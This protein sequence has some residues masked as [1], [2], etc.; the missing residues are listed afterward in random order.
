MKIPDKELQALLA[1]STQ[2]LDRIDEMFPYISGALDSEG[3][4]AQKA[5]YEEYNQRLKSLKIKYTS[6]SLNK[7][8]TFKQMQQRQTASVV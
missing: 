5:H 7:T 3:V 2:E 8:Q 4:V 6:P 1:W